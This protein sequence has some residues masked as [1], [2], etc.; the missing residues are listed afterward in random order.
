MCHCMGT[1]L[2]LDQGQNRKYNTPWNCSHWSEIVT[3]N[4]TIVSQRNIGLSASGAPYTSP[5]HVLVQCEYTITPISEKHKQV[6]NQLSSD[7]LHSKLLRFLH[8]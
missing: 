8:R 2:G 7:I 1:G 3:G 6:W 5:G 4:K